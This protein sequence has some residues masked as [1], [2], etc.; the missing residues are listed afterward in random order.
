M[1]DKRN[2]E[3]GIICPSSNPYSSLVL[4]V[5]KQ[6]GS[7]SFCVDYRALNRETVPNRFPIPIIE[8]L[9]DELHG[10]TIFF[11]LDLKSRYHQICICAG[12]NSKLHSDLMKGT[13]NY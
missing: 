7:W 11:K 3:V 2:V 5:N 9:L 6:D 8:E 13:M 12:M 4:L 1:I 10:A